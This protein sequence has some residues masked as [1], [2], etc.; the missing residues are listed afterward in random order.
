M[1]SDVTELMT[2]PLIVTRRRSVL[3]D[4]L[5]GKRVIWAKTKL[6]R[7]TSERTNGATLMTV[8]RDIAGIC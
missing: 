8:N 2:V 1:G 5:E 3:C 6:L 4:E 7:I